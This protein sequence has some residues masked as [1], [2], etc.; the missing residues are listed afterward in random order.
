MFLGHSGQ[1]VGLAQTETV[2]STF[3]DCSLVHTGFHTKNGS[4][5][6]V[7]STGVFIKCSDMVCPSFLLQN[8]N[9][10]CV[11]LMFQLRAKFYS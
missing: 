5:F 7:H 10:M 3:V 2:A 4:L 9:F 1:T 6:I 8:T 11:L